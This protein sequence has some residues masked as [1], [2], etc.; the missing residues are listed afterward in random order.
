[1]SDTDGGKFARIEFDC[2]V[3]GLIV[4][5]VPVGPGRDGTHLEAMKRD[6]DAINAAHLAAVRPLEERVKKLE[7]ALIRLRDC[8]WVVSLPDRMDAVREIAREALN[9]PAPEGRGNKGV[10]QP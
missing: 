7:A 3:I 5:G 10:R 6:V 1:M 4:G 9:G 8:D 2:G